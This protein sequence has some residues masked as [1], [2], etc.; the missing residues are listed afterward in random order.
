MKAIIPCAGLG[1]R[2]FPL[3]EFIP[4]EL[5]PIGDKKAIDYSIQE[6][7][8]SGI[9]EILIV[10]SPSK[11]ELKKYLDQK[12][13]KIPIEYVI[14]EKPLGLGHA[15]WL[16]KSHVKDD[17]VAILLPDEIFISRIPV[18]K[19]LM[20]QGI[21][22]LAVMKVEDCSQ[23]GIIKPRNI[24]KHISLID[25]IVEKPN[26]F[27]SPSKLAIVGRYA[28]SAEIFDILD[29]GMLN[30]FWDYH[31]ISLT[32]ALNKL[33][34]KELLAYNLHSITRLDIGS[35]KGWQEAKQRL[36]RITA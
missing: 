23:Y 8:D 36:E 15:V 35:Y 29:R 10:T 6:C 12:N 28:L 33:C 16:C 19:I 24:F 17:W 25:Y 22:A 31:E 7:I 5:M 11:P 9:T 2:L 21:N 14:Q 34:Q 32:P 4:K 20:A 13:Y 18:T 30:T 1:K 26:E 3:T 27:N